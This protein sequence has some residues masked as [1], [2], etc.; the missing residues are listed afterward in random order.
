MRVTRGLVCAVEQT[1]QETGC[2]L[3][4]GGTFSC[5]SAAR[6]KGNLLE[7][8]SYVADCSKCNFRISKLMAEV[9]K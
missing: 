7:P 9:Y 6:R 2:I 8:M 3:E 5:H 1:L 4:C